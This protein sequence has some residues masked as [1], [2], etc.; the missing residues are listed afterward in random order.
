LRAMQPIRKR[1]NSAIPLPVPVPHLIKKSRGRKVPYVSPQ[2][3]TIPTPPKIET[4]QMISSSSEASTSIRGQSTDESLSQQSTDGQ[5]VRSARGTRGRKTSTPYSL[6]EGGKRSYMCEVPGCGKCFVR[7][8]HL[9][10]HVRSI[11]TYDKRTFIFHLLC[12]G[13]SVADVR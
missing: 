4:A 6:A 5:P 3:E 1:K 13:S 8:E 12:S 2:P 11:H 7:G 9:K 10:R